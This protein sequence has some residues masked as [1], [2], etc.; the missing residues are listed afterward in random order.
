MKTAHV[1]GCLILAALILTP[2]ALAYSGNIKLGGLRSIR[3][4]CGLHAGIIAFNG[5][6]SG[7]HPHGRLSLFSDDAH[8]ARHLLVKR[9]SDVYHMAVCA[10]ASDEPL[11]TCFDQPDAAEYAGGVQLLGACEDTVTVVSSEAIAAEAWLYSNGDGRVQNNPAAAGTYWLVGKAKEACG[12]AD[13][14][15]E[16]EPCTPIRLVI[17][18]ALTCTDGTAGAAADL[19]ALKAEMEKATDDL[20]RI[21]AALDG[22]TLVQVLGA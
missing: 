16:I 17:L 1:L 21:A 22:R 9:G 5:I 2:L 11:G 8:T 10:A 20:R 7:K 13:Q 18:A 3:R 15:I 19:T 6:G 4:A 14:Q 12:A